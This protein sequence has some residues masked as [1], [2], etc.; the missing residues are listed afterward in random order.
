MKKSSIVGMSKGIYLPGIITNCNL[1]KKLGIEE[2]LESQHEV[3]WK[4]LL[5]QN[6]VKYILAA[7][8]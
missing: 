7:L 8:L 3:V 5:L 1:T 2:G 4:G 6:L